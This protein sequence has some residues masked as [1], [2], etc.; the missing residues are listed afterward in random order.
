MCAAQ[1][2]LEIG[3]DL[4]LVQKVTDDLASFIENSI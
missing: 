3:D 2:A 1:R 4:A